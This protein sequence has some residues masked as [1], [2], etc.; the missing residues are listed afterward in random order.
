[1]GE[2]LPIFQNLN[3]RNHFVI[4]SNEKPMVTTKSYAKIH[5]NLKKINDSTPFPSH[6]FYWIRDIDVFKV[7]HESQVENVKVK[8]E[9]IFNAS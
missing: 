6:S 1:M 4:K 7:Y 3:S 9:D 5:S 8:N 2:F